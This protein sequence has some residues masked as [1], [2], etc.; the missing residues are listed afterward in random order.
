[1]VKVALFVRLEAKPE[2]ETAVS[3]FLES[4]PPPGESGSHHTGLVR[5]TPGALDFRYLRRLR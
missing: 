3:S 4:S 5:V 2:K 1:M